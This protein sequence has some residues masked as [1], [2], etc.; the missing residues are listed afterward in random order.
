MVG[1]ARG[2]W[3]EMASFKSCPCLALHLCAD[4]SELSPDSVG[5]TN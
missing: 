2:A 3:D 1:Q 5:Y 4:E